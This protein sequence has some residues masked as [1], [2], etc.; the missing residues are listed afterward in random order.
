MTPTSSSIKGQPV[1]ARAKGYD[2]R[3][4]G[5]FAGMWMPG[6][7]EPIVI[8]DDQIFNSATTPFAET[9]RRYIVS[10]E[11]RTHPKPV[12]DAMI[13]HANSHKSAMEAKVAEEQSKMLEQEAALEGSIA[14]AKSQGEPT[15]GMAPGN[16]GGQPSAGMGGGGGIPLQ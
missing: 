2:R 12:Q 8:E 10:R 15:G 1:P 13:V 9:H 16:G 14:A 7:P 3:G 5:L 6:M 4:E 11:F